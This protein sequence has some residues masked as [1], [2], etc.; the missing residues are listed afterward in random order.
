M[1]NSANAFYRFANVYFGADKPQLPAGWQPD[2]TTIERFREFLKSQQASFTDAEFAA[3]RNWIKGRI[4]WEFYFRAFDKSTADRA[5]WK[6]DPE[7]ER[8]MES[9]PKAQ[10]LLDGVQRVMAR[11]GVRAE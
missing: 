6:D 10:S 8:A 4:R 9:M 3:N 2:D 5:R 7:I 1:I 11:R